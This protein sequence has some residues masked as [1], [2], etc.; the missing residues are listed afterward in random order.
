MT[1]VTIVVSIACFLVLAVDGEGIGCSCHL[2]VYL[3]LI[4]HTSSFFYSFN[5]AMHLSTSRTNLDNRSFVSFTSLP[6]RLIVVAVF[7]FV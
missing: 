3:Y 5:K 2:Q 4:V 1:V 7:R 6:I